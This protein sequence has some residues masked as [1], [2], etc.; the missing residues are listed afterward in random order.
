MRRHEENQDP[1]SR[2]GRDHAAHRG[3]EVRIEPEVVA[4]IVALQSVLCVPGSKPNRSDAVRALVEIG[5]AEVEEKGLQEVLRGAGFEVTT[6][7]GRNERGRPA[8]TVVKKSDE[9]REGATHGEREP[10][11]SN[12]DD[13]KH[14]R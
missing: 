11:R 7:R 9:G 6:V 14:A 3:V 10:R 1:V 13:R 12:D 5:L 2:L 8:L 4:R